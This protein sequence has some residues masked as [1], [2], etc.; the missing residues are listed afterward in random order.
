MADKID[1][2]LKKKKKLT[3]LEPP[4]FAS[5]L[6][7]TSHTEPYPKQQTTSHEAWCVPFRQHIWFGLNLPD[8]LIFQVSQY[9]GDGKLD[10][11]LFLYGRVFLRMVLVD[12][13]QH[14]TPKIGWIS[15]F[16][17]YNDPK[18][19]L[20]KLTQQSFVNDYMPGSLDITQTLC[21]VASSQG[22]LQR[23]S[24]SC[25]HWNPCLLFK[26]PC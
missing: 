14:S 25:K 26:Q 17:Q 9:A 5:T 7:N 4:S 11:T 2:I 15:P 12:G 8:H 13:A 24:V 20:F 10:V 6:T 16:P 21:W 3:S 19:V 1:E 18:G 23:Y 22:S